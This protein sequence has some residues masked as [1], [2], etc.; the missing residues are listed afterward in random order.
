M[1]S[2]DTAMMLLEALDA[3]WA[4][5]DGEYRI[6]SCNQTFRTAA[7]SVNSVENQKVSEVLPEAVGLERILEEIRLGEKKF[8]A[9]PEVAKEDATGHVTYHHIIFLKTGHSGHPVLIALVNETEYAHLL[10]KVQQQSFEIRLMRNLMNEKRGTV[11]AGMIGDSEPM[12]RLKQMIEKLSRIPLSTILIRGETGTGKSLVARMI[13]LASEAADRPFVE[14]NCA[15]VPETLLESELFGHEKGAFTHALVQKKGLL[16]EADGGSL[17]LDEIGDIHSN[18]QAK[19]LTVLDTRR[20]RRLGSTKEMSAK[21]RLIAATNRDLQT[22]VSEGRF[23]EDLF[24]RIQVITVECPPLREMKEDIVRIAE[25]FIEVYSKEFGKSIAGLSEE[26]RQLLMEYHWPGN[27]RELRNVIE[28]AMIFAEGSSL[29]PSDLELH[30]PAVKP[31]KPLPA[32]LEDGLSFTDLEKRLLRE[33]L[34]KANGNQSKAARSLQ[35]SRD[36]FRYR[37][38]KYNLLG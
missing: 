1:K 23:R 3:G 36:A 15:A 7:A 16:E 5:L 27:V 28:R 20:Y 8:F 32:N 35:M 38:E 6:L 30:R 31:V 18:L 25:H 14:F 33:A 13:H 34:D 29:R 12:Q 9:I 19:L 21:F 17:F 10:Q 11:A 2:D 4:L 24:Y 37:L 22:M 26:S